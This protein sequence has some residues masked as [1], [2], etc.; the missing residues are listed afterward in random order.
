[1]ASGRRGRAALVLATAALAGCGSSSGEPGDQTAS[2]PASGV[3]LVRA[4]STAQ[5]AD[6]SD[7]RAGTVAQRRTTIRSIRGQL[8]P[9]RS[10]T[11][12][13]AL[14]DEAA[15]RVFDKTC[16]S[17]IADSLRLYKLYARAQAFAPLTSEPSR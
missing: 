17:G 14:S 10:K 6:C 4:G 16:S 12:R 1:M 13:S 5:F 3:G 11:A 15:Y 9:Q 8:T 2:S 7:W